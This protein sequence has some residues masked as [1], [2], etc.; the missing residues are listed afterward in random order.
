MT[1]LA[2]HLSDGVITL[3]LGLISIALGGIAYF[4]TIGV[5]RQSTKYYE[6][7]KDLKSRQKIPKFILKPQRFKFWLFSSM[8]IIAVFLTYIKYLKDDDIFLELRNN[9]NSISDS[10]SLQHREL[11]KFGIKI[12]QNGKVIFQNAGAIING[13]NHFIE[14]GTFTGSALKEQK[15]SK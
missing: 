13:N 10:L 12:D 4:H 3:I 6:S 1:E 11:A 2:K 14:G 15:T 8:V 5:E 9:Y 7:I